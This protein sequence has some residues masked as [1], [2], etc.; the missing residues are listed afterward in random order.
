MAFKI[1]CA[2]SDITMTN[3]DFMAKLGNP[4]D[5]IERLTWHYEN[6]AAEAIAS[7]ASGMPVVGITSNTAP[8][9]LIRAAGAFPCVINSGNAHH[10]DI[11][12]F[13]EENVFEK[14]IQAIFGAAISGSLQHLSLLLISRT[15]EQEYKLYLYLREVA[16]QNPK[17]RMPPVYLY[18]LLHTRTTE[19]YSYGLERTLHLKERLEKLTGQMI[20]IA[21]LLKAMEE[22]NSARSEIR[23]LLSLRHP[24]PRI[25]GTEAL[26]LIG[27]SYFVNRK[28]YARLAGQA[29]KLIELREPLSGKRILITGASLN[30]RGLHQAVEMH[31]A[32]VVAEDDWWGSQSAGLDVDNESNDLVEAV[33]E[34]Y[35]LDA[36]SPRLFPLETAD[37]WFQQ[38]SADGIDG[39]IFYLPAE[40]CVAGWDY[41][42]RRRFLDDRKIPHLLV[43]EDAMSISEECHERIERFVD[44]I[45]TGQ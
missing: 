28:D 10:P 24:E 38:A 12:N 20:D 3:S 14:R 42:R 33:F 34:K 21:A 17:R 25:S 22:S 39:V 1:A 2:V 43:R 41:P 15:S 13:M 35:Y 8:W 30:H 31:R 32:I 16:R 29:V 19:S 18:D 36:P 37:A 40:D 27:S 23:K 11:S 26:T 44:S 4:E 9:E 6:P 7:A 5:S 45:G